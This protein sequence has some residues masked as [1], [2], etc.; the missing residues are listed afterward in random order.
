MSTYLYIDG[1]YLRKVYSDKIAAILGDHAQLQFSAIRDA[2][3]ARK[4]FYY[5]CL[6]DKRKADESEADFEERVADQERFFDEIRSLDGFHVHL[7]TLSGEAKRL[8]QKEVDVLLAVHMLTQAFH[9]NMSEVVLIAGDRDFRPVVR[10]L[11]ELGTDVRVL[12]DSRSGSKD[13]AWAADSHE[14][15]TVMTLWKWTK[16]YFGTQAQSIFPTDGWGRGGE[17][18]VRKGMAGG[19]A[20]VLYRNESN[21]LFVIELPDKA[22]WAFHDLGTLEAC[23]CADYGEVV[24]N[25]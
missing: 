8:R 22:R 24:W 17:K 7:G 4:T 14:P 11:V 12:Y 13:L 9:R 6:D 23:V 18:I 10:A 15:I 3:H 5:D 2:V 21:K 20:L 16:A 19:K 1:G 25:A